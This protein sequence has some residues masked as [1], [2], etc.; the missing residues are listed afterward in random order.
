M[1]SGTSHLHEVAHDERPYGLVLISQVLNGHPKPWVRERQHLLVQGK[2]EGRA[3]FGRR[4]KS[5][6][7][8]VGGGG[9]DGGWGLPRTTSA[10]R[11]LVCAKHTTADVRCSLQTSTEHTNSTLRS[12]SRGVFHG[13][14][15]CHGL[16]RHP[17]LLIQNSRVFKHQARNTGSS[18][19]C[20]PPAAPS[21]PSASPSGT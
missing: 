10:A 19:A 18:R 1:K 20:R 11:V 2:H 12:V 4:R 16:P 14:N 15:G 17:R 7:G 13:T 8:R 21:S 3:K 5:G 9:G 6:H